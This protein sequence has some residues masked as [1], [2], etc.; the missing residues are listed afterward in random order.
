MKVQ[1]LSDYNL[2]VYASFYQDAELSVVSEENTLQS[3]QGDNTSCDNDSNGE[4]IDG[5]FECSVGLEALQDDQVGDETT[6]KVIDILT[7][8]LDTEVSCPGVAR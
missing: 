5:D 3:N 2:F 6:Q 7:T 1:T 4:D 8:F